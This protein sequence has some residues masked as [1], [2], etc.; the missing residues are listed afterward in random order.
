VVY[1]AVN[2]GFRQQRIGY[3][4]AITMVFFVIVL[5]VAFVQKV[6]LKSEKEME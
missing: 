2:Q 1:H 5:A 4:S 3:A 6:M